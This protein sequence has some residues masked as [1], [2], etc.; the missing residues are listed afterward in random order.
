MWG[1]GGGAGSRLD[2]QKARASRDFVLRH[3]PTITAKPM[4][5]VQL[6][7]WARGRISKSRDRGSLNVRLGVAGTGEASGGG[8]GGRC[9]ERER[10]K[11][12]SSSM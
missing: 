9:N 11:S 10:E 6:R 3:M 4:C 7:S 2:M 1:G 8:G 12:C 5:V